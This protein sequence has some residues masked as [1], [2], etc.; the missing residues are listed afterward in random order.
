MTQFLLDIRYGAE[1]VG[2]EGA[3]AKVG[4]AVKQVEK[5]PAQ[6]TQPMEDSCPANPSREP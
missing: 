6:V 3:G 1:V 5:F 2:Q 4:V